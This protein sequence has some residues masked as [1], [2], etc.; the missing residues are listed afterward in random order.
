[1]TKRNKYGVSVKSRKPW[2]QNYTE[3]WEQIKLQV[4]ERDR[5]CCRK[6][7]A[8]VRG[9]PRRSVH[10]I[11]PLSRGGTNRPSNL[12]TEC[13]DCHDKEHAHLQKGRTRIT[14]YR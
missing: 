11:I 5:Y 13:G 10:H 9:I 3:D 8:S 1:V 4:Y 12:L 14:K 6:C 7:G 2:E